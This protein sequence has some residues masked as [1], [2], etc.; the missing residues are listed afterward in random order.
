MK[1][2]SILILLL[3]A[4]QL[5]ASTIIVNSVFNGDTDPGAST[6][7]G[8]VED[9]LMDVLFDRGVILFSTFNAAGYKVEG[10]KDA[11]FMIT[12]EPLG[13]QELVKW[14]FQATVNGMILEEGAVSFSEIQNSGGLDNRQLY[15]L[16]GEEVAE[17]IS[18]YL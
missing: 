9:G 4:A 14:K 3:A 17:K 8:F 11:R 16:I 15:Y 6:A 7:A 1:K 18:L 12:I 13:D 2:V 5:Y 10:A